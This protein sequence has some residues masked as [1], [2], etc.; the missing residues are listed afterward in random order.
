MCTAHWDSEKPNN[1]NAE[2]ILASNMWVWAEICRQEF[3]EV[4]DFLL[5]A[6]CS[7]GKWTDKHIPW[8]STS[9]W[10]W[11]CSWFF[12]A[13]LYFYTFAVCISA[14]LAT[15]YSPWLILNSK[16]CRPNPTNPTNWFDTIFQLGRD[17]M[18]WTSGYISINSIKYQNFN[19]SRYQPNFRICF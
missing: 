19:L 8:R 7:Y 1:G 2:E 14:A 9:C 12:V 4:S 16:Q 10:Q 11:R 6:I 5:A 18:G 17:G 15:L 3:D 13:V